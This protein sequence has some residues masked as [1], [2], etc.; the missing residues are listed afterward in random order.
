MY[1]SIIQCKSHSASRLILFEL[2]GKNPSLFLKVSKRNLNGL[3]E[4]IIISREF[5]QNTKQ[6][7]SKQKVAKVVGFYERV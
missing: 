7:Q 3:R 1:L 4:N 6:K 2:H 5:Y